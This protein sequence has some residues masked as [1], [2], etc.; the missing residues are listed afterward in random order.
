MSTVIFSF[1]FFL[2]VFILIGV[3]SSLKREPTTDDYLIAGRS[4]A[5]W[6]AALSAVATNNSGFMFIGMIGYTY[7]DGIQTVWMMIGWILGDLCAWLLVHPRVREHS[8]DVDVATLPAL[9]GTRKGRTQRTIIVL[10]GIMT[11]VLLGAYAAAQLQAGSTAL[12]ALFGWDPRVGALIGATIVVVYCY[13]GGIRASIWTDVA[14]SLVMMAAMVVLLGY[15][16]HHVGGPEALWDNLAAQDASLVQW[17]PDNLEFGF[18][19]F[20]LGMTFG[21]FGAVGQ[22]H[23]LVRF[24]AIR[25]VDDIHRARTVY[26]LWFIPFFIASIA[27]GLYARAVMPDLLSMDVTAGMTA[28]RASEMAMPVMAREL[29]PNVLIGLTLAGLFSATMSTADSQILV[30]SGAI[31]QDVN[32]RWKDSYV[33]SKVATLAVTALALG[34]ALFVQE[35]V[36][37]LVLIAW[38][39]LGAGLGPALILRLFHL[40]VSSLT[41]TLMLFAGVSTVI[42]WNLSDFAGDVFDL[43]PGMVAS[44]GTYLIALP[45]ESRGGETAPEPD[46]VAV[47]HSDN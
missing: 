21:G 17:F 4:V 16:A 31:T 33:A 5:P 40:P 42:A 41:F 29:M 19:M 28:K 46:A 11:F 3:A 36:F 6:L 44:F 27:V 47:D 39:G 26:F 25:S 1:L 22:P 14:Q 8:E 34:I 2:G 20:L 38:S 15:A 30:C 12:K 18:A 24:M 35:G 32:P 23:I 43:F 45:F 13:S 7:R 37:W 9:I 10:A